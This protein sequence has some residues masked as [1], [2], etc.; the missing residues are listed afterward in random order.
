M[1]GL[2]RNITNP[3]QELVYQFH[4]SL[5][6]SEVVQSS[7]LFLYAGLDQIIKELRI[8]VDQVE[9]LLEFLKVLI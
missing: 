6:V 5:V 8:L 2:L 3:A 4:K 1:L 9:E 7:S